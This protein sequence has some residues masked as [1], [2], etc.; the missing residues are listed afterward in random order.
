[1][2]NTLTEVWKPYPNRQDYEISTMGRVRRDGKILKTP[3]CTK[4]G[5]PVCNIGKGNTKCVY[6]LVLETFI[7]TRPEKN[8]HAI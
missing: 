6:S 8:V 4:K 2:P 5:Y 7:G 3:Y 1:M